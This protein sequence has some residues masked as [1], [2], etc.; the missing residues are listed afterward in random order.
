MKNPVVKKI[1][2]AIAV[3]GGG[4]ILLNITFILD[5]L[6][7]SLIVGVVKLFM[8][9]DLVTAD[10]WLPPLM[11]IL[12]VGLMGLFSWLV[13]RSR[14]GV[15]IKAIYMPV[16]VALGLV[17]LGILFYRWPVVAYTLGGGLCLG[18]MYGFYKTK[19]PWLYY[20]ALILTSLTL[21]IFSLLGG[22]I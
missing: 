6:F 9:V 17:I 5:F 11:Q 7:G 4:F 2:E 20:Y 22:E 1:L 16:P 13:F 3:T 21:V 15:M 8:P 12:F 10:N 18:V 19:Q 14:L